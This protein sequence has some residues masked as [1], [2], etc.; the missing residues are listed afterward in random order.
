MQQLLS[1]TNRWW[2]N[3]DWEGGDPDLAEVAE[4][5][6][7]YEPSP[8]AGVRPDGVYFMRGP[9]RVGKTVE[10]KRLISRLIREDGVNPRRIVHHACNGLAPAELRSLPR[11]ASAL[12]P[13]DAAPLYF[14][15]DEITSARAGWPD[16]LATW[17]APVAWT[18]VDLSLR[19]PVT[20]RL[21]PD[22]DALG[23]GRHRAEMLAAVL[24]DRFLDHSDLPLGGPPARLS[25]G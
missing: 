3:G 23:R 24:R 8:L 13:R 25:L 15:L 19:D 9:R 5:P 12:V 11:A 20:E 2:R 10:V 16:A 6:F 21:D 18:A 7:A 14:I 22:A 17:P 4:A 1:E